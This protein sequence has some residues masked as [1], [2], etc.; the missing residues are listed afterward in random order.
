VSRE[1]NDGHKTLKDC[2]E[3]DDEKTSL[4]LRAEFADGY[5]RLHFDI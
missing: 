5:E 1:R 2:K 3:K 4:L